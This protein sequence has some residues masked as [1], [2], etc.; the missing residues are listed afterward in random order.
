MRRYLSLVALFF[1][2]LS[3]KTQYS[4]SEVDSDTRLIKSTDPSDVRI[5]NFIKPYRNHIEN[6]LN[7]VLCYNPLT[8]IKNKEKLNIPLS[9]MMADATKRQVDSVYFRQTGKHVDFVLLNYGGIRSSLAQ[10]NVTIRSAFDLMPFEN[11]AVVVTLKGSQ[12]KEMAQYLAQGQVPHPLSKEV[13][14]ILDENGKVKQFLILGHPVQDDKIY[15]VVTSD[16]LFRGGDKMNFFK[17]A[18]QYEDMNYTLRNVLID[19]FKSIDT[20]KAISDNRFYKVK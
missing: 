20:L 17:S 7:K 11:Q 6:D 1:L 9:N 14:L 3:C 16:Y 15:R 13:E 5:D 4:V 12:L 18:L 19:Y 8:M 10:G 2:L